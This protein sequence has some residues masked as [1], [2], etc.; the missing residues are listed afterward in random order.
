[1]SNWYFE[2]SGFNHL[3]GSFDSKTFLNTRELQELR[4]RTLYVSPITLWEIMLTSDNFHSDFLLFSA[5]NLFSE[6]LLATP[7]ELIIRYLRNAYPENKINYEIFT[8]LNIGKIWSKMTKNNSVNFEYNKSKLIEKTELIRNISNNLPS[9]IKGT[10]EQTKDGNLY[11][12][13]EV[14]T[15]YF[16]CLRADGFLPNSTKYDEVTLNKLVVLFAMLFFVLR[17]DLD[18]SVIVEFLEDEGVP[19]EDPT[20][21]LTYVFENYS[22][23]FKRGPL[24]EMA[25][26][27][28]NQVKLGNTNR[29]LIL[30]CYHMIYAPYVDWIVT[31]DDGFNK[32]QSMESRYR[33]KIIHVSKLKIGASPYL[34]T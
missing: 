7:T 20:K 23:L 25:I 32:L 3:V 14:L 6:Q 12:I 29:G 9:I 4:G 28:Y 13:S 33:E 2:T 5:Q 17:L 15:V 11:R 8:E 34:T 24:L 1:M 16:E 21:I 26:M 10:I 31:G 22:E 30:D 18:S 19:A 27:A